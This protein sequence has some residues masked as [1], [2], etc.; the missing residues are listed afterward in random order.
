M[1]I[2]YEP[3]EDIIQANGLRLVLLRGY[4]SPWGQAAKAMSEYKALPCRFAALKAGQDNTEIK[5]WSGVDSAPVIA[6]NREAP[7]NK[8]DEILILLERLAPQRP[9]IP[10]DL[11]ARIE[12]F[13]L[14]H[15]ICGNLGFGWNRRLAGIQAGVNAG[16]KVGKFG[17]KYGYSPTDGELAEQRSI[18]FLIKLT[19]I[20]KSQAAR[21]SSFILGDSITALDFYWAAFSNLARIQSAE[22]C[23][24][25]TEIRAIFEGESPSVSDAIDPILIDHRDFIMR[26]YF[27]LPMEL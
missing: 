23:P 10:L 27:K 15:A 1:A 2:A 9:L 17:E 22:S 24:L 21:G 25:N 8:W 11:D 7:I 4:P 13:G 14:A 3:I 19:S 18:D 6:W 12:F 26:Q 20:L 5:T 16:M